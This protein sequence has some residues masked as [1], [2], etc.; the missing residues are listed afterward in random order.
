[1]RG[2]DG[3]LVLDNLFEFGIEFNLRLRSCLLNFDQFLFA[4]GCLFL[5]SD[6]V[7]IESDQLPFFII[8]IFGECQ[9]PFITG[10][11]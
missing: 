4:V 8:D 5:R 3:F 9:R 11:Q 6:Q 1:M 2:Y 10:P 7:V